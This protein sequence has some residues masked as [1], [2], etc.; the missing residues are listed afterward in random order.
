MKLVT[1]ELVHVRQIIEINIGKKKREEE[2]EICMRIMKV[3]WKIYS[4]QYTC[5]LL[6][7]SLIPIIFI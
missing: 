2:K 3:C 6:N 5:N 7:Y 4:M 1:H